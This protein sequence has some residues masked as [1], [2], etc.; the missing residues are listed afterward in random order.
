MNFVPTPTLSVYLFKH[1]ERFA[2]LNFKRFCPARGLH[3]YSSRLADSIPSSKTAG[4]IDMGSSNLKSQGCQIVFRQASLA[5]SFLTHHK[6]P[7]LLE[8][9]IFLEQA[10]K[11]ILHFHVMCLVELP[12]QCVHA[13]HLLLTLTLDKSTAMRFLFLGVIHLA[14]DKLHRRARTYIAQV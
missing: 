8:L 4:G 10:F 9:A 12:R 5:C 1:C 13:K 3:K 11:F 2:L 7:R 14:G 6:H